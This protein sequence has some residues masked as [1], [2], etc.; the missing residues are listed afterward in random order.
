MDIRGSLSSIL[1]FVDTLE[2]KEFCDCVELPKFKNGTMYK[3][4]KFRRRY[5]LEELG[6]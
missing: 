3:G 6:L 1:I 4:M 2:K 5:T